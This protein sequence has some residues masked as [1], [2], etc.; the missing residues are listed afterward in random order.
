DPTL[1]LPRS[2]SHSRLKEGEHS[3]VRERPQCGLPGV[4]CWAKT[5]DLQGKHLAPHDSPQVWKERVGRA[6]QTVLSTAFS[7]RKP[8]D[9]GLPDGS[10]YTAGRPPLAGAL[11]S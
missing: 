5:H 6:A 9:N 10:F 4:S 11:H 3:S 1:H 8:V 7:T 2:T